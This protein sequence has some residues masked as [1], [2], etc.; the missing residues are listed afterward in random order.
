MA[1]SKTRLVNYAVKGEDVS[2]HEWLADCQ[3]W[4]F[5]K[6][7]AQYTEVLDAMEFAR[8]G[9]RYGEVASLLVDAEILGEVIDTRLGLINY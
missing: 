9:K 8:R 7:T 2:E 4:T 5:A 6:L 3:E 1:I